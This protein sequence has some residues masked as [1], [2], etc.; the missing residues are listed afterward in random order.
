MAIAEDEATGAAAV[1][2][3]ARLRRSL[4]IRQG[5]GSRLSTRLGRDGTVELGGRVVLDETRPYD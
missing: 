3:T 1:V 5:R 4:E 2:I